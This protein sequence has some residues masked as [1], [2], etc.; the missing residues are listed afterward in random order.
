MDWSTFKILTPSEEGSK[1]LLYKNKHL[2]TILP[3]FQEFKIM[4]LQTREQFCR[5]V[6]KG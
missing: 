1:Q 2:I 5:L 3:H 6:S 4:F